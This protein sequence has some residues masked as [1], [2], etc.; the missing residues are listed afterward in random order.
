MVVV[1][2]AFVFVIV[3]IADRFHLCN[4]LSSL[5]VAA[6]SFKQITCFFFFRV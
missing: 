1:V 3:I 5:E 2:V 6:I 4:S